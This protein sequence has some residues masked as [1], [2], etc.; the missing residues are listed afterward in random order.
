MSRTIIFTTK[1]FYLALCVVPPSIVRMIE[2]THKKI[3]PTSIYCPAR[4]AQKQKIN[5]YTKKLHHVLHIV[6]LYLNTLHNKSTYIG[7]LPGWD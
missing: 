2:V 7:S 6:F 3:P 4:S 1:L 5:L